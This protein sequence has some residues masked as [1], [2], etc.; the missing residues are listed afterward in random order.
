MDNLEELS[1]SFFYNINLTFEE[2]LTFSC[3]ELWEAA[4]ANRW[5]SFTDSFSGKRKN[6][7]NPRRLEVR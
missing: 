2:L 6:E 1:A 3:N 4:L 7:Q 5:I